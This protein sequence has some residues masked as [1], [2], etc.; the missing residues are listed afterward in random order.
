MAHLSSSVFSP[1]SLLVFGCPQLSW[2]SPCIW[3]L[4]P[5]QAKPMCQVSFSFSLSSIDAGLLVG[6]EQMVVGR[7]GQ[8]LAA[9][10][11]PFLHS[12]VAG[13]LGQSQLEVP[14]HHKPPQLQVGPVTT[15]FCLL[16]Y[17]AWFLPS[18]VIAFRCCSQ[19]HDVSPVVLQSVFA[20]Q[21]WLWPCAVSRLL[22][23][24]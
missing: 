12:P 14:S 18:Q 9:L 10:Q 2:N 15:I 24:L 8:S 11:N 6:A 7:A 16:F 20:F 1:V 19:S 21:L 13:R 22:F 4:R 17:D 5:S 23:W 3:R